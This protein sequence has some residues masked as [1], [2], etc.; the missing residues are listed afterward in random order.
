MP[1]APIVRAADVLGMRCVCHLS[2][3]RD[4]AWFKDELPEYLFPRPGSLDVLV[5]D[6]EVVSLVCQVTFL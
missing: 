1:K 6:E 4:Y 5:I 3:L 2:S